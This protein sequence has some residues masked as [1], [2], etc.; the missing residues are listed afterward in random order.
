MALLD[1]RA[2]EPK[3]Q[4][5]EDTVECECI[6]WLS[7]P[8]FSDDL[9]SGIKLESLY[10]SNMASNTKMLNEHQEQLKLILRKLEEP[11]VRSASM[12]QDYEDALQGE[13][14]SKKE[15]G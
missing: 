9:A 13:Q 8:P 5:I 4:K 3:L 11:I 6:L 2:M 14:L 10:L 15:F 1:Q 7:S 12:L